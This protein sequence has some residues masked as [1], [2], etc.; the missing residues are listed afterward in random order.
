MQKSREVVGPD[1]SLKK[2]RF[3]K[4]LSYEKKIDML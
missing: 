2:Y 1:F 4:V 3:R